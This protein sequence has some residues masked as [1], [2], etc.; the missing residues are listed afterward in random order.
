MYHFLEGME[1]QFQRYSRA[2]TSLRNGKIESKWRSETTLELSVWAQTLRTWST[3]Q[4]RNLTKYERK[5]F[6]FREEILN[7]RFCQQSV[8]WISSVYQRKI[9][10]PE[11]IFKKWSSHASENQDL[12][13]S[14]SI[15]SLRTFFR[16]K[17]RL[18][19]QHRVGRILRQ[20]RIAPGKAHVFQRSSIKTKLS[21][22]LRIRR[23][24]LNI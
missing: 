20:T 21:K 5:W 19:N 10:S 24:S 22:L 6:I 17:L 11:G 1:P 18:I 2:I 12:D 8:F 23:L 4:Y 13:H 15:K 16:V 3:H 9:V 14:Y 7:F